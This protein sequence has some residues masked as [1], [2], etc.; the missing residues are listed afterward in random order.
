MR[1]EKI[2]ARLVR[3][4]EDSGGVCLKLN[5]LWY[6]GIPDRLLLLPGAVI[7]FVETKTTGGRVSPKQLWWHTKLQALGFRVEVPWTLS[8]V[9]AVFV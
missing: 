1:E 5:P 8:Q 2:E 6:I 7:I 9:D 4:A 3:L